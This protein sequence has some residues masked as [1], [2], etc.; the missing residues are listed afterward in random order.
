MYG[1]PSPR[2][3]PRQQAAW[4]KLGAV[5]DRHVHTPWAIPD[6]DRATSAL[7][8]T[9]DLFG[10][11]HQFL[12]LSYRAVCKRKQTAQRT[13][14]DSRVCPMKTFYKLIQ[15]IISILLCSAICFDGSPQDFL[16]RP[17]H[18]WSRL[19]DLGPSPKISPVCQCHR[20]G[21]NGGT[22]ERS[23]QDRSVRANFGDASFSLG[24]ERHCASTIV[25]S[26]G[27]PQAKTAAGPGTR[28]PSCS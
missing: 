1:S 25:T 6:E 4:S 5:P 22:E 11:T 19:A 20:H 26:A 17:P 23:C 9:S 16:A 10:G 13:E 21:G 28:S 27:P 7:R 18:P 12:P 8:P 3:G 14:V 15:S 2:F 24:Y